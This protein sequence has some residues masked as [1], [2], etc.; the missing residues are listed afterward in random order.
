MAYVVVVFAMINVAALGGM[1]WV[2]WHLRWDMM[3]LIETVIK[4]EVK[5]QDDRIEKR[6]E[7]AARPPED[8]EPTAIESGRVVS[9]RP[10]RR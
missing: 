7:R 4:D 6:L 10:M 1:G 9:G 2:L 8:M 5:K 3:R